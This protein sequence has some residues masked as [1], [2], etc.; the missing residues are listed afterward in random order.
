MDTQYH[1]MMFEMDAEDSREDY[2]IELAHE[3]IDQYAY[4][5]YADFDENG[6]PITDSKAAHQSPEAAA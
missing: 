5:D 2:L 4:C 1:S 6:E 3:H